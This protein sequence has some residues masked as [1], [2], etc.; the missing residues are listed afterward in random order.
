MAK[1]PPLGTGERFKQLTQKLKR[2]GV[3]DPEA[4]AAWIGRQ[5]Y[6]K[7]RF[8]ELATKGRKK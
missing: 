3:K 7:Q 1:K 2:K 6:G 5:K 8:Q 4:L